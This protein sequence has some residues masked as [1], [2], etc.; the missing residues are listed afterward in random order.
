[1]KLLGCFCKA[2]G[3]P[4]RPRKLTE[5][6]RILLSVT[7]N[8]MQMHF[9]VQNDVLAYSVILLNTDAHNPM[10]KNKMSA[11]DFI[12]NNRGIND[13][14]DLP[15]E[16]MRSLY[17]QITKNEIKLKDDLTSQQKQS[18]SIPTKS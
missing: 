12:R 18:L 7:G 9:P 4:A 5:S 17:E 6:W 16:Y 10:V 1:M 11:E 8:V 14:K 15:E 3:C 13:G 2:L